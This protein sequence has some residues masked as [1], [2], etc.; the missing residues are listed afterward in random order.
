[1]IWSP[2]TILRD[3]LSHAQLGQ[4]DMQVVHRGYE[5]LLVSQ[6]TLYG[7]MKGNKPDFHLSMPPAEVLSLLGSH[8]SHITHARFPT[9]CSMPAC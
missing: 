9:V 7:L 5:I 1:M 6:F 3:N 8:L 4:I 2:H